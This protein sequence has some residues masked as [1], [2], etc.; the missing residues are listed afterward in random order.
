MGSIFLFGFPGSPSAELPPG[1]S[2]RCLVP[3]E[4]RPQR[5]TTGTRV[6]C[7]GYGCE[8]SLGCSHPGTALSSNPKSPDKEPPISPTLPQRPACGHAGKHRGLIT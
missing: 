8:V 7:G 3:A 1:V 5:T 6:T 2:P 4:T